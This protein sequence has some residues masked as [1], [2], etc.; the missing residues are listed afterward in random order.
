MAHELSDFIDSVKELMTD[1]QY[2]E[3]MELCQKLFN[4]KEKKLYTMT[5]LRPYTFLDDHCDDDECIESKMMISFTKVSSL[6][7][8]TE[9]QA[10]RIQEANLFL[11]SEEEMGAFIDVDV[12]Q[13]FPSDAAEIGNE[14]HWYEFPVLSI[15]RA[16]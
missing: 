12:L 6:I 7:Q 5:Y 14:I 11:G 16:E 3:G 8:L 10:K 15:E 9:E 1:A 2:K 13:S 4:Q